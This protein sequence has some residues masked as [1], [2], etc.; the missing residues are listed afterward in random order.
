MSVGADEL[1]R[2]SAFSEWVRRLLN[3]AALPS[4]IVVVLS[5]VCL[6][7]GGGLASFSYPAGSSTT[8]Y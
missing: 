4:S 7:D 5:C 3:L 6:V 8:N 2:T 1:P